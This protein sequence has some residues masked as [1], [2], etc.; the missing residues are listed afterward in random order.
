[1]A[2]FVLL[3]QSCV[4]DEIYSSSDPTSKE[5]HSKSLW[6]E[7]EKYIKNVMKVYFDNES[8]IKKTSGIPYWGYATTVNNFDESFLMVP[9]VDAGK[10]FSVLKVPRHGSKIYFYYTNS[11]DDLEFFQGLV[12]SKYKKPLKSDDVSETSKITCNRQWISI[13]VPD[14]NN[15]PDGPG[16]WDT[17]S[18]IRCRQE[19]DQCVGVINELGQCEGSGNGDPGY[20]Y[21]GGGGPSDPEESEDPCEK[22]KNNFTDAKFNEKISA[23][24]KPEVFGYDHEMGYAAGY[25][26]A[27]TGLTETQYPPME[28]TLGTH[29]VKLPPGNQYFGY[30]HTHNDESNGGSPVKIFSYADLITFLTNCV[31]NADEHGS[32]GDAYCMVITSEGNYILKYTGI[33]DYSIGPNQVK[34]WE[35]WYKREYQKLADDD[36]LTQINVEKTF[37]R[38]LAES[39]KINGLEIYQV[40]KGTGKASKINTNGIKIPCPLN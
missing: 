7:D 22:I 37:A 34:N 9:V 21:P 17:R 5:Y 8:E 36:E 24:D 10:V 27:N 3:L 2:V 33:G 28:N 15:N 11:S 29:N 19:I 1:M 32:I 39:V 26:P 40:E 16:H 38:F 25:P 12:F 18:V 20:P 35:D 4:H 13:W 23:I 14:N 6:K 31:R 30:I